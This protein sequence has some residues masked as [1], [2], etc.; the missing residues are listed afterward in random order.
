M[1]HTLPFIHPTAEVSP[2][3]TIGAG[4][5]IW[6][7]AQ[8]REGAHIGANCIV[9]KGVYVDFDVSVGANSKLQ[10]GVYVYHGAKI[11]EGVF[12]GPGVILTNDQLPR[13]INPDGSLKADT[14][15]EVSPTLVR[16]G[17]SIG[18]GVVVLPGITIGEF[19]MIGAG[20]VVTRDV[21]RHGLAY[22]NPA[23]LRGYVC[24]CGQVLTSSWEKEEQSIWLCPRCGNRYQFDL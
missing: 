21:P 7:Q 20:A 22:G 11:E 17:A 8:V 4:V 9:G 23:R 15:W 18:A 1:N 19:A 2:Q 6:H 12:L 3:A 16:R 13:A 24:H 10:N 5:K 14:D